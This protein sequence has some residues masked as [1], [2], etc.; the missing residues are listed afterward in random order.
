MSPRGIQG[1]RLLL[2]R[3]R[4]DVL[5]GLAVLAGGAL[6]SSCSPD[7]GSRGKPS[8]ELSS[9]GNRPRDPYSNILR[10]DYV[11]PDT[12]G[13]CH[14]ENHFSWKQHPHSRMNMMADE[15]SVL[16]DFS[17]GSLSYADGEVFFRRQ[18]GEFRM[19][20]ARQGKR[21][22]TYKVTRTIGWRY[23]QE[24]VGVQI[25]GPEPAGDLLYTEETRLKFGYVLKDKRWLPQSYLDS[26]CDE[27]EYR[28][29]GRARY[30]PFE[31]ERNPFNT[32]CI[33]CHNTYPYE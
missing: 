17:G 6:L 15:Q 13:K 18:E 2:S 1:S 7:D 20:Y 32:R 24:Y 27:A 28:E 31:P 3:F 9:A 16:G 23:L 5:L 10:E 19:E 4:R 8:P 29:D 14:K 12:C 30:D 26:P 22:R 11:G 21:V 33:H 25:Q